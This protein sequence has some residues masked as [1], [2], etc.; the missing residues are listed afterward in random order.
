MAPNTQQQQLNNN[1]NNNNNNDNN[2]DNNVIS[3]G[4]FTQH[5]LEDDNKTIFNNNQQ[6]QSNEEQDWFVSIIYAIF[7]VIW[8]IIVSIGY[9]IQDIYYLTCG[10]PEKD[11]L[12]E[13]ALVTG[14]GSGLGRLVAQR[15]SQMGTKVVIWDINS[16]GIKETTEI[17][18]SMGGYCKGYRVDISKKDEVYKAADIVRKEVGDVSL[19]VNNAGVVS[20]SLLLETPDHLIERS[21]NVNIMAH[22]WTS[23]AFLPQMIEKDH[24]HIV[25]IASLA[26]HIGISKL[27][28]YCA[29]KFAAVGFDEALRLELDVLGHHGV[30]TTCICP[31]FIQQTG[32]FDDVN[33]RWVPILNPNDVADRIVRAIR[34]NEKC[35]VI[36]GYIKILLSLKWTF[37]WGCNA[38]FLRRL[39]V[40][41]SPHQ[42]PSSM[43]KIE[44][45]KTNGIHKILAN[46]DVEKHDLINS[47]FSEDK[48]TSILIKRSPSLG[49]R[50][51]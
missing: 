7:D 33:A 14:G 50:V 22:F 43:N 1:N 48:P 47:D 19:L 26:G 3:N 46:N 11:L 6:K 21:F 45:N 4:T 34:T 15:L 5:L 38:G 31:Y 17:I 29:S 42:Q 24:G 40:D 35:A 25:T 41:A 37:P 12:N 16:E 39:V 36:P 44:H 30:Q 8:F 23:K 10:Y 18:Q 27:V 9:I 20:G 49:E 2:N 13:I 51:L 32:M 28:D